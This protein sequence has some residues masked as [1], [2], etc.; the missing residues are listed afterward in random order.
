MC[1]PKKRTRGSDFNQYHSSA[2]RWGSAGYNKWPSGIPLSAAIYG[3]FADGS[4]VMIRLERLWERVW[5]KNW[6]P[7]FSWP[8]WSVVEYQQIDGSSVE[9]NPPDRISS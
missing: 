1:S 2:Q 8:K 7:P 5:Y 4:V 6:N 3:S 9:V